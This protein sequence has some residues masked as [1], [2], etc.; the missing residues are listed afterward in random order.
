MNLER[1]KGKI[2]PKVFPFLQPTLDR[3]GIDTKREVCHFISQTMHESLKFTRTIENL[4]YSKERLLSVFPKYFNSFTAPQFANKPE[5]IANKVYG[6]RYGNINDGD[7]WRY[8]GRGFIMITF[9]DNYEA[10]SKD[11][12]KDFIVNPDLLLTTE[13]AMLS[14]GWFFGKY[15]LKHADSDDVKLV[16][17]KI[18]G[19]E[20]GL[21]DRQTIYKEL[22][23]LV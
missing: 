22:I 23:N 13:Y 4:N 14:A 18:N 5:L 19:G 16:T 17:K 7:G 20:I 6:G 10:L 2:P 3:F 1:I 15:V 12:G 11:L 8:R 21:A 9:K